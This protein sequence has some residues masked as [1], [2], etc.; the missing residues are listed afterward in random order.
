MHQHLW[1][2]EFVDLLRQRSEPP[3]LEHDELVTPE[4]RFPLAATLS[5]PEARLRELDA[6]D[7]D[8]AVVSLQPSL[9]VE[10]LPSS[11][12]DELELAWLEGIA[13]VVE[14]SGGRLV[15][16]APWRV[17][18]GLPGTSV[19]ACALTDLD[20][21]A[22]LLGDVERAGGFVFVHPE[23]VTPQADDRHDWWAPVVDYGAQMQRA[24]FSWLAEGRDRFPSLRVVFSILAGGAPFQLERRA[25]RGDEADVRSA[26]DPGVFFD[27]ATYGRRAIELCIETFG[28]HQL[29]Y[30]SDMPVVDPG[31]T[32]EAVRGFGD[33][34]AHLMQVATPESLLR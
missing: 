2:D 1:P 19:G 7:V 23:A 11:E 34:V 8:V 21:H 12:R 13:G 24:Y 25:V 18:P 9:G 26:L 3:F 10:E 5:D 32:L 28:I 17:A 22:S 6:D 14:A 29:V 4:G 16:L 27:V 15:A 20:R 30:G 31:P 33:S